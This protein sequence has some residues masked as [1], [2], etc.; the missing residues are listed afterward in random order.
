MYVLPGCLYVHDVPACLVPR[1]LR[2]GCWVFW[3]C[4]FRCLWVTVEVLGTEP[5]SLQVLWTA[6]LFLEPRVLKFLKLCFLLSTNESIQFSFL[7]YNCEFIMR[8]LIPVLKLTLIFSAQFVIED[9]HFWDRILIYSSSWLGTCYVAHAG[10]ELEKNPP[11]SASWMWSS[12]AW[13]SPTPSSTQ[14]SSRG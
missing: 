1:E 13:L 10:L 8:K 6:E 11:T 2:R 5:K 4:Y 7:V 3:H 9:T 12:Q 14:L